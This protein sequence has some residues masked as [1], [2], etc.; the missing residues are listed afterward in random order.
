MADRPRKSEVELGAIPKP[1]ATARAFSVGP[2]PFRAVTLAPHLPG[3]FPSQQDRLP[4]GKRDSALPSIQARA[5][6]PGPGLQ[7]HASS[8]TT[9]WRCLT[10]SDVL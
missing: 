5:P 6:N 10:G 8:Q 7:A 4:P 1:C 9:S 2:Q 3:L